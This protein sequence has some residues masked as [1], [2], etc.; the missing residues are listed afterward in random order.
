[1]ADR[2]HRHPYRC[3]LAVD[4]QGHRLGRDPDLQL[5]RLRQRRAQGRAQLGGSAVTSECV[6]SPAA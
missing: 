2:Q 4:S 6:G 3:G 1:V 5:Q